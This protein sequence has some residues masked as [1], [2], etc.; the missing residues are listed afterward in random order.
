MFGGALFC[1][2]PAAHANLGETFEQIGARYGKPVKKLP[3]PSAVIYEYQFNQRFIFVE[4]M[5]GR[6]S[7]EGIRAPKD[8][9][10]YSENSVFAI[11]RA[12]SGNTNWIQSIHDDEGTYWFGTN[13]TLTWQRGSG[14]PDW[15]LVSSIKWNL[16][17]LKANPEFSGPFPKSAKTNAS[18][19]GAAF[20]GL[21]VSRA[22]LGEKENVSDVTQKV[23]ELLRAS[24]EGFAANSETLG[25]DPAPRKS[26]LLS[27][28]YSY[29]GNAG[30]LTVAVP[31]TITRQAFENNVTK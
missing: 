16:Y 19:S 23:A 15:L 10:Q 27:V 21:T 29:N 31:A 17:Q 8:Y 13:A 9:P 11:A 1:H 12:V 30:V 6:S 5:D 2:V 20:P 26:K 25:A 28:M 22:I 18:P 24:P 14:K 7:S 4:Y 3:D